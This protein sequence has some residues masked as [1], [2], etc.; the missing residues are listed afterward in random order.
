MV[1]FPEAPDQ[2]MSDLARRF[3]G[4]RGKVLVRES[5]NVTAAGGPGLQSDIKPHDVTLDLSKAVMRETL[6]AAREAVCGVFGFLNAATPDR[7][8]AKHNAIW[9]NGN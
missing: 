8:Y 9:R 7:L 2:D 6:V 4:F 3:R 1:P 5:V